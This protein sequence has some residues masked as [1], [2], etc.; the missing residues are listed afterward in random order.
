ML[1]MFGDPEF[2]ALK[3]RVVAAV[4][5]GEDPSVVAVTGQRFARTNVRVTLRQLKA[6]QEETPS[7]A[8]W[9]AAHERAGE[10]ENDED[11]HR[12]HR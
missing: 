4:A 10:I 5:A 3:Q 2:F 8:A 12:H 1:R 7:L 11:R 9:M 6:A